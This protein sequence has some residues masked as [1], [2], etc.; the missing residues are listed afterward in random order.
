M[1]FRISIN[2][3]RL[4]IEL[5]LSEASQ[6]VDQDDSLTTHMDYLI[7]DN[8]PSWN[9]VARKEIHDILTLVRTE[10]CGIQMQD[11]CELLSYVLSDGNC[12]RTSTPG[13]ESQLRAR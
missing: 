2:S 7:F 13:C 4:T 12:G 11:V 8:H 9:N 1:S 10:T 5:E 6:R 3:S